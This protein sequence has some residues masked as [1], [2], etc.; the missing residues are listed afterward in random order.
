MIPIQLIV[1]IFIVF[2]IVIIYKMKPT[3]AAP[4]PSIPIEIPIV[5]QPP[6]ISTPVYNPLP[7]YTPPTPLPVIEQTPLPT[8]IPPPVVSIP[9]PAP[10][11]LPV[12]ESTPIQT[13]TP[14]PTP[15]VFI[16]TCQSDKVAYYYYYNPDVKTDAYQHWLSQGWLENRRSCWSPPVILAPTASAPTTTTAPTQTIS[17]P[18]VTY[19]SSNSTIDPTMSTTTSPTTTVIQV[20]IIPATTTVKE[21]IPTN[22]NDYYLYYNPDVTIDPV[23]HFNSYGYRERRKTK[24]TAPFYAQSTDYFNTV[25]SLAKSSINNKMFIMCESAYA[26]TPLK[27]TRAERDAGK[28]IKVISA[29]YGR[30]NKYMCLQGSNQFICKGMDITDKMKI[31]FDGRQS[32]RFPVA[33]FTYLNI[34]DPCKNIEKQILIIYQ[35]V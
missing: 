9:T 15:S 13:P 10:A 34:V 2:I 27:L 24:Y 33:P 31:L 19:P 22:P 12:V 3:T 20:P 6:I 5:E 28:V 26:T 14:A 17:V 30:Y 11:P 8:Y 7:T 23:A 29:L 32:N 21:V 25:D 1:A 4:L 35:A 18:I 16:P